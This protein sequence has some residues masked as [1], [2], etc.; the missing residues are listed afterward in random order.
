MLIPSLQLRAEA[1]GAKGWM[2][3]AILSSMFLVQLIASPLWGAL[4]DRVGRKPI[5]LACTAL[6]AASMLIYA[7]ADSL[8][9]LL[10]TRLLSG[11]GAANIA[12]VQ[13]AIADAS[14]KE[15]RTAEMGRIGA[16]LSAGLIAGPAI[17]GIVAGIGSVALVGYVAAAFSTV[18]LISF[19]AL[20]PGVRPVR[21]ER[22]EEH[23]NVLRLLRARPLLLVLFAIATVGWFVLACLE[24]TFGRLIERTLN[25]GALLFG[26]IFAYESLLGVAVQGFLIAPA[27]RMMN[28]EAGLLTLSLALQGFGLAG[29]PFAHSITLLF[30]FSTF[31]AVGNACL[32]P[33]ING[34]ASRI[35]PDKHQGAVFGLLQAARSG[36]FLVGPTLG[37]ALFDRSPSYPYLLAGSVS[38]V[39]AAAVG[40]LLSR[41]AEAG[42]PA[43]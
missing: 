28:G 6:S 12:T 26:I 24:G 4:S 16:A 2:I 19:A 5:V 32:N 8:A 11:L 25:Q 34:W 38:V 33:S 30:V 42:E 1:L 3:G 17:G 31:Y 9:L 37:G 23:G 20:F 29:M 41:N 36:G 15:A 21:D 40:V 7:N 35:T 27:R 13:A 10:A 18:G 14:G 43:L 22:T 39:A